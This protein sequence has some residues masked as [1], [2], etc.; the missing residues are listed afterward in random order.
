MKL[1]MIQTVSSLQHVVKIK[2]IE[3]HIVA[4]RR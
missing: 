2:V 4:K 1:I 3:L